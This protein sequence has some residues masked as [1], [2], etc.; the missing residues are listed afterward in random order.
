MNYIEITITANV[1][2][3]ETLI[4]L[5]AD[6]DYD[7]FEES[8]TSLKAFIEE[9]KFSEANLNSVMQLLNVAYKKSIIQKQNWNELWE[10]NFEPVVVDDF[11]GIRAHFHQPIIGVQHEIL[12]TPKMSFGTGHHATTFSV[13]QLMKQI[14]F[15]NKT[16]FDFGTGTGILAILAKKL[17][18]KTVL[19]VDNDDWCIENAVENADKNNCTSIEI[20]KVDNAKCLTVFDVVIA[21]IN[22][23]IILD[24]LTF[25][26]NDV[27]KGGDIILSGLLKE[28]ESDILSATKNIGWQHICTQEKGAWIAMLF[29]N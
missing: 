28:D 27:I 29:K 7:G 23:N 1:E 26:A 16:V 20:V 19:A 13:M 17:G 3:Q 8:D 11:V 22:K 9:D 21:N 15:A 18:A 4:A 14:D 5:L 24:N 6:I 2:L 10:S 12:I 25:L